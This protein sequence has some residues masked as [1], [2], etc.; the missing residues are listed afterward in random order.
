MSWHYVVNPRFADRPWIGLRKIRFPRALFSDFFMKATP[1][2]PRWAEKR[3]GKRVRLYIPREVKMD[4][5]RKYPPRLK[6]YPKGVAWW[7][8][9]CKYTPMDDSDARLIDCSCTHFGTEEECKARLKAYMIAR[10]FDRTWW[11]GYCI[12]FIGVD[13]CIECGSA[14]DEVKTEECDCPENPYGRS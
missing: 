14:V 13:I 8:C 2:R 7:T 10:G 1:H 4:I 12:E 9:C 11:S 5:R 6:E 3:F